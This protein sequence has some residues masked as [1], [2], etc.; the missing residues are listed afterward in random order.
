MKQKTKNRRP[1]R[2]VLWLI[3]ALLITSGLVRLTTGFGPA[4]A[5]GI[6]EFRSTDAHDNPPLACTESEDVG[7]VLK[8]LKAQRETLD[9]REAA[10]ADRVAA[11]NL[12]EAEIA[13]NMSALET[14]EQRLAAT[15]ALADS[16]A[17]T[18]IGRLTSV[19]ENMKPKEAAA[20]FEAMEPAFS[21]GFLGRMRPES[22]AA[23]MAG[24]TPQTA[25]TI[26]VVLAGRNAN[27]PTE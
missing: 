11:L 26:S 22:A 16:A 27:V 1:P 10:L 13:R 4:L 7:P 20:L 23:I 17:E 8:A 9:G 25:Y 21:A 15:L 12:V 3:A 19:Y 24:L 14:A 6:E 18:D 2:G 5:R